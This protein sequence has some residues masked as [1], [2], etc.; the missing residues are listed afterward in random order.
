[1]TF[2]TDHV[3]NT[4]RRCMYSNMTDATNVNFHKK[5][6]R[7]TKASLTKLSSK[8]RAGSRHYEP[9]RSPCSTRP[10]LEAKD[11]WRRI[12]DPSAGYY[13]PYQRWRRPNYG[14]TRAWW[15]RWPCQWTD[16][17][18][19]TIDINLVASTIDGLRPDASHVFK[20]SWLSFKEQLTQ[21]PRI[22]ATMTVH[23]RLSNMPSKSLTLKWSWRR[24]KPLCSTLN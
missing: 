5:R 18:H 24:S 14:A 11:S 6:R 15:P 20:R 17:P 9:W 1:M 19:S 21:S 7:V 3:V 10:G 8:L 12:Q 22:T 13:R 16:Y 4:Y 2:S 23:A